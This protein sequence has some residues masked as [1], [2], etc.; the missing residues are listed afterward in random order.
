MLN[1]FRQVVPFCV[2]RK[3]DYALV[4]VHKKFLRVKKVL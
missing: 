3:G 2:K 4:A 1:R